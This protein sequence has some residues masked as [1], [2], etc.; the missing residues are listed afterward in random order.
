MNKLKNPLVIVANGVFP[1]HPKPISIL[2]EA[3]FILACDGAADTLIN[4]GYIPDSIIGD[5]DSISDINKKKYKNKIILKKE[6]SENDLRKA[7]NYAINNNINNISIIASSGKREDHTIGNIF[8]LFNYNDINI[9]IYTDTGFFRCIHKNST[10]DSF[11]GQQISIFPE[12]PNIRIT[13]NNLKYNFNKNTISSIY[14]G[15]LNES[16]G[17]TFQL[18]ISHGSLLIFQTY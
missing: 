10:I 7:I 9:R 5:L 1:T 12:K 17:D 15:T 8:S 2:N 16:K 18:N 6:Q 11:K 13:S 14:K 4:N 3:N